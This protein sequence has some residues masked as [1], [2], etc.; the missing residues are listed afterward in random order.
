MR[1]AVTSWVLLMIPLVLYLYA[2]LIIGAPRVFATAWDSLLKQWAAGGVAVGHADWALV[3]LAVL[4]GLLL[5]L[6]TIGLVMMFFQ[7]AKRIWVTTDERPALRVLAASMGVV[8][9]AAMV[10]VWLPRQH[11]YEPIRPT[12]TGTIPVAAVSLSR[13]PALVG[14]PVQLPQP[15]QTTPHP[16]PPRRSRPRRRAP[17][18]AGA[19]WRH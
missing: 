1:I 18:R 9:A 5:L 4:Q 2:M 16:L 7:T 11:N 17:S 6:P 12:E 14:A 3:I 10:L 13:A 8:I 15:A 19:P